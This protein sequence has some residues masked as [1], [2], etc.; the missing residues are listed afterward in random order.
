MK[1]FPLS[2]CLFVWVF[3]KSNFIIVLS[4]VTA[5]RRR[6]RLKSGGACLTVQPVRSLYLNDDNLCW[7]MGCLQIP[8]SLQQSLYCKASCGVDP[9]DCWEKHHMLCPSNLQEL[10]ALATERWTHFVSGTVQWPPAANSCPCTLGQ[11]HCRLGHY[12]KVVLLWAPGRSL[13]FTPTPPC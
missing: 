10:P 11:V 12:T 1:G 8:S 4:V 2:F 6:S 13:S 3:F 7:Q 5:I 9:W